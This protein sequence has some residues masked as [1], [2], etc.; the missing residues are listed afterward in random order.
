MT[1]TQPD[2]PD[3][4]TAITDP[5]HE[6]DQDSEPTMNAPEE[7]RPD[8]IGDDSEATGGDGSPS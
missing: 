3:T 8:G 5:A 7:G 1:D 2:Q 4:T 6:H